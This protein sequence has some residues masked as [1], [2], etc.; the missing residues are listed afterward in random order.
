MIHKIKLA[1]VKPLSDVKLKQEYRLVIAIQ[2][3]LVLSVFWL[4]IFDHLITFH[5]GFNLPK[6]DELYYSEGTLNAHTQRGA[7]GAGY[8]ILLLQSPS[9]TEFTQYYC[10][11]S[12]RH[13]ARTDHCFDIKKIKP[14]NGQ[15]A[16]IGWYYQERFLWSKNPYPQLVTLSVGGV[17][18]Y[19]VMRKLKRL[20]KEGVKVRI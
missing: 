20:L 7:K 16:T 8:D 2:I 19:A 17:G 18:S 15:R 11:Y 10:G 14:Y 13:Y 5:Q 6:A 12:A 4:C 1:D 9:K 3:M